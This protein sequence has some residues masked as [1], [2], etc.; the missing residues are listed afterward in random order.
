MSIGTGAVI[1]AGSVVTKSVGPYEIW[2]GN[3]ARQVKT[4]FTSDV[5]DALLRVAWW[6]WPLNLIEAH[7]N[8]LT[9]PPDE[10]IIASLLEISE[11]NP[12]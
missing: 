10:K 11:N 7:Q 12:R 3:P 9:L 6:D 2:A 1:G 4:R 8:I 5:V